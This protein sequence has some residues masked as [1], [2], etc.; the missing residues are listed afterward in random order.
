[1]DETKK[2][3]QTHVSEPKAPNPKPDSELFTP[4]PPPP[5]IWGISPW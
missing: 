5:R 3:E 1:M 4:V 2:T